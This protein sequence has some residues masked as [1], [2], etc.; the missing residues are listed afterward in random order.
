MKIFISPELL[1]SDSRVAFPIR[2]LTLASEARLSISACFLLP[3][4]G[5]SIL[6]AF[7]ILAI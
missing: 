5:L 3:L 7:K 1:E 2:I 6:F 4:A